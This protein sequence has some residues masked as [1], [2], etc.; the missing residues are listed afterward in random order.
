[1]QERV[2][3]ELER[4]ERAATIAQRHERLTDADDALREM[5]LRLAA[6]HRQ[7]E[8]RH[9]A[10]AEIHSCYVALLKLWARRPAGSLEL[11]P[12]FMS[13]VAEVAEST[14]IALALEE[15]RSGQPVVAAADHTANTAYDLEYVIG[16]GP[17]HRVMAGAEAAAYSEHEL[18]RRWPTYGMALADLGVLSLTAA[19]LQLA[20]ELLGAMI[21]YHPG[22]VAPVRSAAGLQTLADAVTDTAVLPSAADWAQGGRDPHP[23][24]KELDFRV[25]LHQAAGMVSVRDDCSVT[26]ALALI[27][28]R[29]FTDDVPLE[30]VATRVVDGSIELT[31]Q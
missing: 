8:R 1:M 11:P 6:A 27:R 18:N 19:P 21:V 30:E 10:A 25:V 26:D 23:L 16:E 3:R 22:S 12:R 2:A 14:S 28:A 4:A 29:S 5:H 24:F 13:A 7:T 31:A 20:G 15:T 9:L 17:M